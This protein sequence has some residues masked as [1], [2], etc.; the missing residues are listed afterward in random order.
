M[1]SEEKDLLNQWIEY[2]DHGNGVAIGFNLASLQK[3]CNDYKEQLIINKVHYTSE[4][5]NIQNDL[6]NEYAQ[7]Y[8]NH[9]LYAIINETDTL[10]DYMNLDFNYGLH[11][12]LNDSLFSK[13]VFIKNKSF[14][15]EK[16]WRLLFYD[17]L[18]KDYDD[19][20]NYFNFEDC[21]NSHTIF[22]MGIQFRSSS[23]NIIS[24]LD[25]LFEK[26]KKNIIDNIIIGPNCKLTQ[27]DIYQIMNHYKFDYS[28]EQS[29]KSNCPYKYIN[30]FPGQIP[31]KY[32]VKTS[33]TLSND[34]QTAKT[35]YQKGG[36]KSSFPQLNKNSSK[37]YFAF[38]SRHSDHEVL[39]VF[40]K[41]FLFYADNNFYK[42]SPLP[43]AEEICCI[44]I[45][46]DC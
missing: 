30:P 33:E 3:I 20:G 35:P 11:A 27:S 36:V 14:K 18:K 10:F 24:Y 4:K 46:S 44:V 45:F 32:P 25:L 19:W 34:L 12:I 29:I 6:I 37:L 42:K 15:A 13:S 17:E 7:N 38:K 2:A 9:I 1:F 40:C 31:V 21:D 39:T 41:D 16:E 5:D 22:P 23:N 28:M 26:Y 8:F 43:K